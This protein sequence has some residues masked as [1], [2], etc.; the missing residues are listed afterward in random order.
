LRFPKI[1]IYYRSRGGRKKAEAR[2][3]AVP[4]RTLFARLGTHLKKLPLLFILILI[5]LLLDGT[6]TYDLFDFSTRPFAK[7]LGLI[8]FLIVL[9]G[10]VWAETTKKSGGKN[11]LK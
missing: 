1:P 3:F 7:I 4:H 2:S 11:S 9:A 8:L 10:I 5:T 6:S